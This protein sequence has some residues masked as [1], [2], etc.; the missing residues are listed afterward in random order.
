M[1]VL[2]RTCTRKANNSMAHTDNRL[3]LSHL[4]LKLAPLIAT[5]LSLRPRTLTAPS[6]MTALTLRHKNLLENA[7]TKNRTLQFS[8][9]RS[10]VSQAML[11]QRGAPIAVEMAKMTFVCLL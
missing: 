9:R 6:P 1:V 5:T 2:V 3:V 11:V 8:H 10:Q 4:K 7:H